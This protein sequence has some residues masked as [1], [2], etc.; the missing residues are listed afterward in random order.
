MEETQM[1]LVEQPFVSQ[2]G[3]QRTDVLFVNHSEN[4]CGL[5]LLDLK[6][7]SQLKKIHCAPALLVLHLGE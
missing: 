3:A 4:P 7:A 6:K 5:Q 1:C 2:R